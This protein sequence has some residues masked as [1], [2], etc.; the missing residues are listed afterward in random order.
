MDDDT[1]AALSTPLGK[2]G[3]AV[4]R[5]SGANTRPI[6]A[7]LI[8]SSPR[9]ISPG[10]A[11]HGFVVAKNKRIDE[12]VVVFFKNPNSYTGQDL[13][14]ISIHSNPF[15]IEEVLELI[16]KIGARS[17]LPGE[18]TYRAFKNGKM[19]LIQAESVNQLINANSKYYA[20]VQ[21]ENMDGRLS[22]RVELLRERIMDLGIR[23]ETV[24]EFEEDQ[25]LK[26]IQIEKQLTETL[27]MLR[28]ILSHAVLNETL[29]RGFQVVL[30]GKVN[31]GKSSLFNSL[32]MQERAIISPI[33]GTTRDYISERIYVEGFPFILVD[34]AGI[35]QGKA[36]EIET[37]G[38]QR[39]VQRI[40]SS[41]AVIFMLDASRKLD[42][43]DFEIYEL[44]KARPKMI[45]AN[46]IDIVKLEVMNQIKSAFGKE[47]IH[48]ISAK[49]NKNIN[50]VFSFF[51]RLLKSL[52]KKES[53]YYLNQRQKKLFEDLD[54]VLKGVRQLVKS[55]GSHDHPVYSNA[56][57]I[58]EEIRKS[59]EIIGHLTGTVSTEEILNRIF[60]R[61][62]VGK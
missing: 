27:T 58:A 22:E 42:Q 34:V 23:I 20:S 61:F 45:V 54:Q 8:E 25:F 41:D 12:C 35:H 2:G 10:R 31:V 14:E 36:G 18:F 13:A 57:I 53:T 4:I 19:D 38:I 15:L 11:C 26:R 47:K 37:L 30:T 43:S 56:E 55:G 62:C 51:N 24:I 46:K 49:E 60:S 16:F 33:P 1:I 52:E 48:E 28:Q 40:Q 5:I 17:A 7:E 50:S 3:I 32:L 59:L 29:N 21:F 6:L 39:G 9:S 44:I